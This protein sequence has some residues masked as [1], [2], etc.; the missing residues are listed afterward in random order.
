[1]R[2]LRGVEEARQALGRGLAAEDEAALRTVRE[3][4][5]AVRTE[6]DVAVRRFSERLDGVG[7]D[8]Y[9]VPAQAFVEA[10][11]AVPLELKQAIKLAAERVRAY[12][13][14]Q[15]KEGFLAQAEGALLGQLVRPLE[16]VACY[17]PGGSASLFSS[18]LMAAV[19]A[20]VAGVEEIV[21]ATPPRR[22]GSVAPEILVAAEEVG[23]R[24]V[25]RVGGAQAIA[26]LAYGTEHIPQVDKIVG[27]GNR[28]VVLAKREVYGTAGIESLPGPT[29][30]LLLADASASVRG[31]AADLLA[32]AEHL[33]AQPVL[34]T[35]SEELVA[36]L[37][38]ELEH[39]LRNLP[40]A[41]AARESLNERGFIVL[42]EDIH[43]G[44]EVANL[45]AP[46]HLC[47]LLADPWAAL[48]FVKNAG[49]IFL[50]EATPEALGDYVA[51]PSHV[52]PTGGTARF[53]SFLNLR[54]FQKVMPVVQVQSSLLAAI[55]PQAALMA[56][57]EGLEAHARALE[58]RLSRKS[59]EGGE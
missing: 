10:E 48:P 53:S 35:T 40:T 23:V 4:V 46:E 45:Y 41:H 43:E 13:E 8:D 16:R 25:Y 30:T 2:T 38:R 44:L 18:L 3:M 37:P 9:R 32:Q 58:A 59:V 27:P 28:Y 7:L 21:V 1:M 19:P 36:A 55:G 57:A 52:M 29:E 15:P 5:E 20:R 56:R 22:D 54:D 49:G 33:G 17:V 11:R 51:G 34:V 24:T 47:L 31:V 14:H 42:V 6:G 39:Q 50:G 26:A 12:Y